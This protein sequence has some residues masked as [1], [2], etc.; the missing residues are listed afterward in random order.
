MVIFAAVVAVV[1]LLLPMC[2][3]WLECIFFKQSPSLLIAM[4]CFFLAPFIQLQE[5]CMPNANPRNSAKLDTKMARATTSTNKTKRKKNKLLT[6]FAISSMAVVNQK[7][8]K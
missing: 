3:C 7:Y 4:C 6:A 5:I 8:D 2:C 1:E